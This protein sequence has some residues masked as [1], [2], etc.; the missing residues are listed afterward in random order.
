MQSKE[1]INV[2]LNPFPIADARQKTPRQTK[3]KN[4]STRENRSSSANS[5]TLM[6]YLG[7]PISDEQSRLC[8]QSETSST[9]QSS[10]RSSR[11]SSRQTVQTISQ[12]TAQSRT[13]VRK[14]PRKQAQPKKKN[15]KNLIRNEIKKFQNSTKLLIPRLPFQR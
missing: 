5:S 13:I 1:K 12:A 3:T 10:R 8:V 6:D 14:Q 7:Q 11:L 2:V 15:R 9:Q 4:I